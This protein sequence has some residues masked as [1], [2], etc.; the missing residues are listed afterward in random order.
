VREVHPEVSFYFLN[1]ERPMSAAK[2][3]VAGRAERLSL[4]R[5]WSGEAVVNALASRRELGCKV[6]DVMDAFVALWTAERIAS[7]SAVSIPPQPPLDAYGLRM[8]MLA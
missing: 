5:E 1:G 7:G 4:L 3:K 8:E 6:D 2:T